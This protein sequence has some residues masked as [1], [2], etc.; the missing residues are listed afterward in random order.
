MAP[1]A[2]DEITD[3][4]EHEF[5]AATATP[6]TDPLGI[7]AALGSL[8]GRG[9]S[10]CLEI[11]CG[12]GVHAGRVRGLGWTPLGIDI[13]TAMLQYTRGRLP[14]AR[15]DAIRLPVRDRCLPAVIT[16]MAHTGM[17]A[18]PAVLTEAAPGPAAGRAFRTRRRPP[19]LLRRVRRP[20]RPRRRGD[21]PRLPGGPL[22]QGVLDH[23]RRR[24][25]GRRHSPSPAQPHARLPERRPDPRTA[26]RRRAHPRHAGHPRTQASMNPGQVTHG[27]APSQ[28]PTH[29]KTEAHRRNDG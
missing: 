23:R 24:G 15:A 2:Y 28:L 11:G 16:V 20:E 22:D 13:S 4:Y 5:L 8:L 9:T 27:G 18:Y 6:G 12:T 14:A 19:V 29:Q 21:P 17:P 26:R 1:A 7:D 3:W 10:A 25:Q